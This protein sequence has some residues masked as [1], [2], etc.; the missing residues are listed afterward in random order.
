MKPET[1]A[2]PQSG[3]TP[4]G[5]APLCSTLKPTGA[6]WNC[7]HLSAVGK[8]N[9][10]TSQEYIREGW[11][12][13][14]IKNGIRNN[15]GVIAKKKVVLDKKVVSSEQRWDGGSV[16]APDVPLNRH[17]GH[18]PWYHSTEH[19]REEAVELRT[20]NSPCRGEGRFIEDVLIFCKDPAT[21]GVSWW[22]KKRSLN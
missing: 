1:E 19:S 8:Q 13:I 6:Q 21:S 9:I 17:A 14:K 2:E 3:K 5:V 11:G 18:L 12:G 7:E 16:V 4:Q 15:K 10:P 20:P 22:P